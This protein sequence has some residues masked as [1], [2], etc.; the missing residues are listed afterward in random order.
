MSLVSKLRRGEGPVWGRLKRAARAAL[1]FHVPVNR[2]TRPLFRLL[3]GLH[4]A[5]REGVIWA[6]RFFWNEP[7]FRS[8]CERVGDRFQMEEL[9]YLQGD[10]RIEIGSGVR[11]SGKP[12]VHFG[13]PSPDRPELVIGDGTFVG[14]D[15]GFNI[16]RS[17]RIG[18]HCLLAGGVQV[19]DADGHPLDAARRRAGEPTP[20]EAVSPVV[21]GDDVWVGTGAVIL[22]GVTIG[23]RAIVGARA[24]VTRDV[25]ADAV[26]VGNP[27]RELTARR[28]RPRAEELADVN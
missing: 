5:V 3:Y 8:Q 6:R 25:P 20:P 14:H 28:P 21:I 26:V 13:R 1:S 15:C 12:S 18:R 11:L 16:S 10:G 2:L 4:V 22:K 27:A 24:V 9:P 17:V 23:D 19:Y 7:L